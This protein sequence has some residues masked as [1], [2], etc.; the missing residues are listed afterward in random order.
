MSLF[1]VVRHTIA[2]VAFFATL[3]VGLALALGGKL[4]AESFAWAFIFTLLGAPL[5]LGVLL[6]DLIFL[7][8]DIGRT[9]L[10]IRYSSPHLNLVAPIA[11]AALGVGPYLCCY[12]FHLIARSSQ[13]IVISP[14]WIALLA[15]RFVMNVLTP[16][17]VEAARG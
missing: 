17:T 10:N 9:V 2:L 14:L 13:W 6:L 16:R 7:R 1:S 12:S 15:H 4:N 8:S 3:F 5:A 11:L